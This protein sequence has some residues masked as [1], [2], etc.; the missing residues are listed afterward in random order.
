MTRVTVRSIF[1]LALPVAS[2]LIAGCGGQ[3]ES[4]QPADG[5]A[6]GTANARAA[7]G[8]DG[9]APAEQAQFR[10]PLL[11]NAIHILS[12]LEQFDQQ[13]ALEQVVDRL[14]QWQRAQTVEVQWKADPL[15]DTLPKDLQ[16]G[17]WLERLSDPLFDRELDGNFLKECIWLRDV[18]NSARGD[19]LDD[20]AEAEHLFDWTVRNIQL[21]ADVKPKPGDKQPPL[22]FRHLPAEVLLYGRGTAMQRAWVF[23]LLARQQGL[24][25]VM[26]GVKD[27]DHAERSRPWVP[28][29]LHKGNLYLFDTSLGLPLPG[30]G[31]KGI[32]TLA[33]AAEDPKVLEQLDLDASH[34]YPVKAAEAKE[35]S[36]FIEASPGYL[37]RR[38]KVLESQLAGNERMVLSVE[39]NQIAERLKGLAHLAKNIRLWTMP[40]GTYALRDGQDQNPR[41]GFV[42]AKAEEF[43][44]FAVPGYFGGT[45]QHAGAQQLLLDELMNEGENKVAS[46]ANHPT[47][48][49]RKIIFPLWA[50]RLLH[51]RGECD[52]E[53]GA[54]HFY[55]LARPGEDQMADHVRELVQTYEEENNRPAPVQKYIAAVFRRKQ[56]ATYWLGLISY[57]EKEYTAAEDYFERLTLKV[58]PIGPWTDGARYN[59][60]RTYE[61][62]GRAAD[63]IKIYEADDSPQ[64]FGNHLRARRLKAASPAAPAPEKPTTEKPA[65]EKPAPEKP[66]NA[67]PAPATQPADKKSTS[68]SA[69]QTPHLLGVPMILK[70]DSTKL[71]LSARGLRSAGQNS[72]N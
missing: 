2:L 30:P 60:A 31:G 12:N 9:A 28:A 47:R 41:P 51:F 69:S 1:F 64:R 20:L 59:L 3:P 55:I 29:L 63:A 6:S 8:K 70:F 27:P 18:S 36:A 38:M 37:S 15:I 40:Q 5:T 62:D 22:F 43:A 34:H 67:K 57:D 50:G 33:E 68:T 54:K 58:W 11:R 26:L 13:P 25:V 72:G 4:S 7:N 71:A 52:G 17:A 24:D 49:L 23:I 61:A 45:G 65:T 35:V 44:P 56:D 42:A 21:I 10:G 39:P 32:A 46:R 16:S 19:K 14:N 48:Q 66:A 53:T